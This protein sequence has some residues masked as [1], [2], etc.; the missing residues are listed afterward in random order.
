MPAGPGGTGAPAPVPQPGSRSAGRQSPTTTDTEGRGHAQ[1]EQDG[2]TRCCSPHHRR[3]TGSGLP[4][5]PSLQRPR[6][7]DRLL[8]ADLHGA[9]PRAGGDSRAAE[10]VGVLRAAGREFEAV[11][12]EHPVLGSP[13][14]PKRFRHPRRGLLELHRR[15]LL[16][17]DRSQRLLVLTAVP[18][19]DSHGLLRLLS[20][21][22]AARVA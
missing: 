10:L 18:D 1:W 11:R 22:P 14:A 16:E 3:F 7:T 5:G 2:V 13:R 8:V 4:G 6:R 12:S 17:P 20:T 21:W 9:Y 19:T 15:T